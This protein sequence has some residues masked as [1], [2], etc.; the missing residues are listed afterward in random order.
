MALWANCG[1]WAPTEP[2]GTLQKRENPR[3]TGGFDVAPTGI[4]PVTFR[5]SV[6]RS[7]N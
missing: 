2:Q 1:P 5:F 4:D 3:R 6:E 7:T